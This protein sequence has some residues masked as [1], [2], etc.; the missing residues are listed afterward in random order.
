[1]KLCTSLSYEKIDEEILETLCKNKVQSMQLSFYKVKDVYGIDF[2]H[3]KEMLDKAGVKAEVIHMPKIEASNNLSLVK[4]LKDLY[5][6]SAFVFHCHPKKSFDE[7]LYRLKRMKHELSSLDAK[8]CY[9]VPDKSLESYVD[10]IRKLGLDLYLAYDTSHS[11][12]DM[13]KTVDKYFNKISVI[14]LSNRDS[15]HK[16]LPVHQGNLPLSMLIRALVEKSYKGIVVLEYLPDF[17]GKLIE[18]YKIYKI[19][20]AKT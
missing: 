19:I 4:R 14:H 10:K 1:M 9:E 8:L 7:E 6:A 15:R 20:L 11:T 12:A 13:L 16:H 2:K 18:D 17:F 5:N 3:Y